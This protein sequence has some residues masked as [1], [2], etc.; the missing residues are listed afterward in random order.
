MRLRRGR[1]RS[2]PLGGQRA[3][4]SART[5]GP[6]SAVGEHRWTL[7][8]EGVHAFFLVAGGKGGVKKSAFEH[9]AVAE[10]ALERAV[11]RFFGGHDGDLKFTLGNVSW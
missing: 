6:H 10:R 2:G 7:V 4:R 9:Q 11:D 3:T 8:D 1:K 5:W